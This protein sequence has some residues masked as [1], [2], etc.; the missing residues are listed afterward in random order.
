MISSA[1]LPNLKNTSTFGPV[2]FPKRNLCLQ[3]A[4]VYIGSPSFPR[5]RLE[6]WLK[7]VIMKWFSLCN[8]P[9][10]S[11][12]PWTTMTRRGDLASISNRSGRAATSAA[13]LVSC[14]LAKWP[15]WDW[16]GPVGW[17]LPEKE[18]ISSCRLTSSCLRVR[19]PPVW[20][21]A[22]GGG[23]LCT[24]HMDTTDPAGRQTEQSVRGK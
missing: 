21:L 18:S 8:S 13:Q 19:S 10:C 11:T 22:N 14:R 12:P 23:G 16:Q 20:I 15:I 3:S 1:T 17:P 2:G 9:P 24:P 7:T 5:N 4:C 6:P